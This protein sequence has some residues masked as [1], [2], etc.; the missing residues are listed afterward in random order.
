M[1]SL[2]SLCFLVVA[3]VGYQYG[4]PAALERRTLL[5]GLVAIW[6]HVGGFLAGI[7][8]ARPLLRWRFGAR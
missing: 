3:I 8:L 1:D 6:A 2:W 4:N 7:L 5:L